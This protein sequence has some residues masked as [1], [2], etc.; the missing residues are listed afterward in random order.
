MNVG[1]SLAPISSDNDCFDKVIEVGL[2]EQMKGLMKVDDLQD[3][4]P[5]KLSTC[6][7][8]VAATVHT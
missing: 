8:K 4:H 1:V 2:N 5:M 7:C 6:P 3:L